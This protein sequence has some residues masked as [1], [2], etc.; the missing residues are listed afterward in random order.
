MA[1]YRVI[2]HD[3]GDLWYGLHEVE[4]DDAGQVA[5]WNREP[6]RFSCDASDGQDGIAQLL[7]AATGD[8]GRWPVLNES[9][10]P[11]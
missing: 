11:R 7:M 4:F 9:E 8:A 5:W 3:Q 1:I 6:A 2:F 10:L